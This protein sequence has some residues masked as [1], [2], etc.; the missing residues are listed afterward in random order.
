MPRMPER[1]NITPPVQKRPDWRTYQTGLQRSE[2][3]RNRRKALTRFGIILVATAVAVAFMVLKPAPDDHL[4]EAHPGKKPPAE[5]GLDRTKVQGLLSATPWVNLSEPSVERVA[6]GVT[7]QIE[8]SL[9]QGLQQDLMASLNPANARFIAIVALAPATGRILAM[10]GH[11]RL[12]PGQNPC[13]QSGFPAASIFKIVTA[14]AAIEQCRFTVDAPTFYTG[15]KH[16]LYKSQLKEKKSRW[17][18]QMTFR[19]AFAESVNPVFGKIGFHCLGKKSLES[20]GKAFGFNRRFAGELPLLPSRLAVSEKPFQWA[21]VACGFNRQTT[22]SPLH[23]ALIAAALINDGL[24]MAPQ[25]VDRVRNEAGTLLYQGRPGQ[26]GRVAKPE[27]CRDVRRMMQAVVDSGTCRKQFRGYRKD[28]VL[29][30]LTIGGKTGSINNRSQDARFDWFVGYAQDK[31]KKTNLAVA[32]M[33]AH[34]K[35][36]GTRAARYARL[37]M[38]SFFERRMAQN[39]SRPSKDSPS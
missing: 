27:T 31:A 13:L 12:E 17:S 14:A 10:V 6:E 34:E 15:R 3:A 36:I 30:G 11:N 23:G 20:Y 33:V 25:L 4:L 9:D 1:R 21:E 37:A 7:Y 2:A 28:R 38:R 16:T 35:Y 19:N 24:M 29:G 39:T 8:T 32:V 5:T 26:S 18:N 22:L